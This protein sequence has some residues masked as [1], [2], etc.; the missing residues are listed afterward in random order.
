MIII[1]HLKG[2]M[3]PKRA[4]FYDF[5]AIHG[6]KKDFYG[7]EQYQIFNGRQRN[8]T[9]ILI[10]CHIFRIE[11]FSSSGCRDLETFQANCA[12]YT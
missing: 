6:F 8:R 12:Y 4:F 1:L 5:N 11:T 3:G 9:I 10:C 7:T 2:P